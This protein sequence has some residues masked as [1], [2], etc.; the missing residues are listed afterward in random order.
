MSRVRRPAPGLRA[1]PPEVRL[2]RVDAPPLRAR[3][4]DTVASALVA[5]GEL[6][7]REAADGSRR[8]VFCGMGV[9][10]ECLVTIDGVPG[11]RA[12]ATPVRD[13]MLVGRQPAAPELRGP[14]APPAAGR[15]A[16]SGASPPPASHE[17]AGAHAPPRPSREAAGDI[18]RG[19]DAP[20]RPS[21]EVAGDITRGAH[22]LPRA[23]REVVADVVVVGGGPAGLAAAAAAAEAGA[24]V[25]LVDERPKLGGQ[26]YKQPEPELIGDEARLDGQYR[27]GRALA[28]RVRAAGVR[29]VSGVQVWG[30]VDPHRLLATDG[31]G[32]LVLRGRRLVLAAGAYERGVPMPGWTLP[33]VMTT[34]AA[35]T[36]LR[37]HQ[38][39][40]GDRIL[41]SG[42]GPLN[43]QVAAELVRAGATVVALAELAPVARLSR[44]PAALAMATA[45]P[46]LARDGLGYLWTLRGVPFHRGAAVV[47]VEGDRGAAGAGGAG[48]GDARDRVR[49]AVVARIGLDGKPIPGSERAYDVD[50][51]CVGFGFLP[52]NELSRSL[53]CDH[54]WDAA[55]GQLVVERDAR[56]RTS[57]DDVWVVGD[58]GG[59]GGARLAQ[60]TGTLAGLDAA[61]SL[62]RSAA[63]PELAVLERRAERDRTR[64]ARFQRALWRLFAAPRL[65]DQLAT[66]DTPICRCESV[67]LADVRAALDDGLEHIGAV[68]RVTRAGMGGCQ[69]RYCGVLLAEI[70]ARRAGRPLDEHDLFAPA[71]PIKPMRIDQLAAEDRA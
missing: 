52:A 53:G 43:L 19:A 62:G 59:I 35:Q 56:G 63:A 17:V 44:L 4:T 8:G 51:V 41:V 36:L 25:V 55:Q 49:R 50:A 18:T 64:H 61:R 28:A 33:G 30:G 47:R 15:D 14:P 39:T 48:A 9:C 11:Q 31:D 67:A 6:A 70:A 20:P 21:R 5:A 69:G 16:A 57:V 37:A 22:A 45:A 60:A 1:D 23:S 2:L 58:G 34:G 3:A 7:C 29:V 38:V 10:Q 46:D 65:V 24:D 27:S 32:D 66:P 26:Y 12:C 54:R 13:G 42:N 40:P 71:A 68:K